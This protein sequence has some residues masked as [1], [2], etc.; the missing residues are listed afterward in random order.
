MPAN[1]AQ[2]HLFILGGKSMGSLDGKRALVFG[3]ADHHSIG[4]GIAEQLRTEGAQLAFTYQDRF[5]KNIRKLLADRPETPLF[6][7]DVQS[8]EQLDAVF[9]GIQEHWGSLDILI[10][11]VAFASRDALNGRFIDTKRGDFAT[12]LDISAYSLVAMAHRAEP[13]MKAAGGGTIL[14]LTYQASQRVIPSYNLMAI[15]KAALEAS[16]RYLAYEMGRDNI[17]VNAISAGPVRTIAAMGVGD[18]RKILDLVE[19]HAPLHRN[20]TTEDVGAMAAFLSG[21]GGRSIT[22]QVI[23][24]DSGHNIVVA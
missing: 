1:P 7:C 16:V 21:P 19:E 9:A 12:S 13:L 17:C 11:A 23:Y 15:S 4:W 2:L 20:I 8:D 5:E 10:H 3:V 22:G 14:A 6:P 24:V 18:V